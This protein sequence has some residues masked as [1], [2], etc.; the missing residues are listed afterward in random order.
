MGQPIKYYKEG[1]IFIQDNALIYI[2]S[3]IKE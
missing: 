1:L 2:V 3:S